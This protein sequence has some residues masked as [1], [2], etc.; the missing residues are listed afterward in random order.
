MAWWVRAVQGWGRAEARSLV[1]E[2]R[3]EAFR[4][5]QGLAA[6]TPGFCPM[7][8]APYPP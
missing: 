4:A 5:G 2:V 1:A 3:G 8:A 6:G 7:L